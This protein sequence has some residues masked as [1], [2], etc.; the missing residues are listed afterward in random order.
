MRGTRASNSIVLRP[1]QVRT[2]CRYNQR[3]FERYLRV[4]ARRSHREGARDRGTAHGSWI[5]TL[6]HVLNVQEAW[7]VYIVRDRLDE[8]ASIRSM[9]YRSPKTW[10]GVRAYSRRVW[11]EI[12]AWTRT[13]APADLRHR[14]R[15]P[16]MPRDCTVSDGVMQAT[17]EEAHHLGEVIGTLWQVDL[18]P[19]EMTWIML[20]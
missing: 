12:G 14:V 3:L 9:P 5:R 4:L 7:L 2:V 16:W 18:E 8:L 20:G 15:A 6:S 17:L 13:V 11:G 19:P 10:A 1:D